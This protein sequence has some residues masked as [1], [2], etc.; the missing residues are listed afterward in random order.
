MNIVVFRAY[1]KVTL[2]V[3]FDRR[4]FTILPSRLMCVSKSSI[5]HANLKS[6]DSQLT[7][8]GVTF[9]DFMSPLTSL[10]PLN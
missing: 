3:P 6:C 1:L 8:G 4:C 2:F 7:S 5:P 9:G 10:S